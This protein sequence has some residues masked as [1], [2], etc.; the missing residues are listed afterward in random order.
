M[1]YSA[2]ALLLE[3]N[4]PVKTSKHSGVISIFDK[5]FVLAGKID[6]RFSQ[7]LHETFEKRQEGDY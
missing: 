2:W 1:C 3:H 6:R 4:V 7:M 5:E